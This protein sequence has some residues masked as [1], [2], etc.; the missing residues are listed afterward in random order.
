MDIYVDFDNTLYS[1][2]K[3]K[4]EMLTKIAESC[5]AEKNELSFESV[6]FECKTM[7]CREK[8][9]NIYELCKFFAQK[10]D[11][12][13][14]ILIKEIDNILQNGGRF[15]YNDSQTF[16]KKLKEIGEKIIL[17]T[18]TDK[19]NLEYQKKKVLGS[20]LKEYFDDIIYTT[21]GKSKLNLDYENSIFFDDNPT[22]LT[23][24]CEANAKLVVRVKRED[25]Q[26]S[27]TELSNKDIVEIV[28]LGQFGDFA[29][30]KLI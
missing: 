3:L 19:G 1:T 7:F 9:Y 21:I 18:R 29:K 28:N 23:E 6:L 17:L 13:C 14:E 25:C 27:Q 11:I 8:I 24:L 22:E 30:L 10:Y 15:V 16:L 2:T 20:G 26:Y 4:D 12:N 5:C